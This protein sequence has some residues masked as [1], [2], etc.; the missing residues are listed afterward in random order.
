MQSRGCFVGIFKTRFYATGLVLRDW[1][2]EYDSEF[3]GIC[4]G[5][6]FDHVTEDMN[7]LSQ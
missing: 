7:G 5:T 4:C 6:N 2:D 3:L 1:E